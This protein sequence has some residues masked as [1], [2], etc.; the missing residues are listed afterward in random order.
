[1]IVV[2]ASCYLPKP[3]ASRRAV[4]GGHQAGHVRPVL[5]LEVPPAGGDLALSFA[6]MPAVA[7]WLTAASCRAQTLLGSPGFEVP[8]PELPQAVSIPVMTRRS[9]TE[10]RMR[11]TALPHLDISDYFGEYLGLGLWDVRCRSQATPGGSTIVFET[12]MTP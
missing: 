9:C 3:A 5:V 1:V 11:R 8:G 12:Q 6:S 2:R 4:A 10:R 7:I